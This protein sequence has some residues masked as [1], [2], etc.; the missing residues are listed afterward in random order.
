MTVGSVQKILQN[1]LRERVPIRDL[2]TI[3]EAL[4]DYAAQTK[5][6]NLLT[7]YVRHSL[8]R[9]IYSMYQDEEGKV[10]AITLAPEVEKTILDVIQ[11]S[12]TSGSQFALPPRFIENLTASLKEL[13]E[14]M[15][16]EGLQPLLICSPS[17]RQHF[18]RLIEPVFLNLV[19]ISYA[20][21]PQTVEVQSY[22]TAQT[23]MASTA[24]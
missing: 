8:K 4:S 6:I 18:K 21:L 23:E 16:G 17:I 19:V 11:A 1:L 15:S 20:E 12:V 10:R 14:R 13:V 2:V 3:L 7:E 5:D 24:T 22:G 9:V